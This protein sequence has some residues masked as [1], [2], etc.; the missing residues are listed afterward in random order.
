MRKGLVTIVI[1]LMIIVLAIASYFLFFYKINCLDKP[2][3]SDAIIN[4]K[5]ASYVY[6]SNDTINLYEIKGANGVNC[7]VNVRLLQL[8]KGTAE[9]EILQG[10]EMVC[11]MPKDSLVMPDSNLN[12]CHG[13]LKENIQDL[14]IQRMHRQIIE[15]L[16]QINQSINKVI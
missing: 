1:I 13:L 15:N 12:N 3:F 11:S 16:G 10:K 9:L 6:E 2:C 8:K 4:C 14:V 7:E 5:R